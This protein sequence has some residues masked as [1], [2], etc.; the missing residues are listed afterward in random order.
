MSFVLSTVEKE[1]LKFTNL[2]VTFNGRFKTLAT[3]TGQKHSTVGT[4]SCIATNMK[5]SEVAVLDETP[6]IRMN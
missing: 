5:V 6:C 1:T 4:L 3:S 2:N